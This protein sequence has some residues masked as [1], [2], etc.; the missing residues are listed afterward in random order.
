MEQSN[1]RGRITDIQRFS[2]HD[3]HGIRTT[4]FL[5]GCNLRCAWCHNPETI[6]QKN[7][8]LFYAAKC[9]GCGACY[10]ACPTGAR[11][12]FDDARCTGCGACAAACWPEAIRMSWREM[13]V[14]EVMNEIRQ[15]ALYYRRSGGGVTLSGGEALCQL[16]FAAALTG[17]CRAEGIPVAVETNLHHDFDAIRPL[18]LQMECVMADIKLMD[19]LHHRQYTGADNTV[20]LENARHLSELGVPVLFRTPL[21]PGVTDT[22]ENLTAIAA[23]LAALPGRPAWELLNFNPL[24]G[25][26]YTAVRAENPFADARPLEADRLDEIRAWLRGAGVTPRIR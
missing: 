21:I 15:D 6:R 5:A 11:T 14:S 16:S 7:T 1:V 22:R 18:L 17:A 23:F 20:I 19:P 26:K 10:T 8:P 4:V 13:T 25:D 9:I 2:L 24:G 12:D 3:G